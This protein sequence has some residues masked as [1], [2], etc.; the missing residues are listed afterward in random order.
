[1]EVVDNDRSYRNPTKKYVYIQQQTYQPN[2]QWSIYSLQGQ[3]LDSGL[4]RNNLEQIELENYST[5]M[6]IL[7]IQD[8]EQKVVFKLVVRE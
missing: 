5:G 3:L 7:T 4:M 1:M 2:S 6:Y 8:E